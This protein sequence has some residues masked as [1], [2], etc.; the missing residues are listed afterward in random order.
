MHQ[1]SGHLLGVWKKLAAGGICQKYDYMW[2]FFLTACGVIVAFGSTL[3][4][5]DNIIRELPLS[6]FFL[7][8]LLLLH[9]GIFF[10]YVQYHMVA[11]L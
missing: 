3:G 7:V 9:G 1:I 8:G 11:S 10:C 2:Q 4:S 5:F 6:F